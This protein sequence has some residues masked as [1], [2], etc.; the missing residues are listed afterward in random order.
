MPAARVQDLSLYQRSGFRGGT[1]EI[2]REWARNRAIGETYGCWK[3][4]RARA[5]DC[6]GAR[7]GPRE[8]VPA[9]AQG[10][11]LVADDEGRVQAALMQSEAVQA[12]PTAPLS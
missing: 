11:V 6:H 8:G 10:G 12:A 2:A 3:A 5:H 1:E 9:A 7:A 4:S